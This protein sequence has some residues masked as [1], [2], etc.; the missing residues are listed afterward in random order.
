MAQLAV[1]G[2]GYVGLVTAACLAKLGHRVI[3]I[4]VN[5]ARLSGLAAG[6]PPI[7]EPGLAELVQEQMRHGRLQFTG[8][9]AGVT[10]SEFAFIAVPTP[11]QP[12]G[13]VDLS[14]IEKVAREIAGAMTSYKIVVDKST[15]PVK[16][17]EKVAETIKRYCKARVEFD[18]VSN[19]EFLREGFAVEEGHET[20]LGIGGAETAGGDADENGCGQECG[21][22]GGE[23]IWTGLGQQSNIL[24]AWPWGRSA[25]PCSG[26]PLACRRAGHPARRTV[27]L[28]VLKCG[29]LPNGATGKSPVQAGYHHV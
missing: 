8:N 17:G 29:N 2:A 3:C 14:F 26:G 24:N 1:V 13:A 25:L 22:H 11:P 19:P 20:F 15:V 27:Q 10:E 7:N 16:T 5:E 4:E 23:G 28:S 18:V 12:D 21:F 9:Y 6:E